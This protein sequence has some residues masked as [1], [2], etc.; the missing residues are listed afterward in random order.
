MDK[1][2]ELEEHPEDSSDP[3]PGPSGSSG[4]A[5][6]SWQPV[7]SSFWST[8]SST[9][10]FGAQASVLLKPATRKRKAPK[11]LTKPKK[12]VRFI[13]QSSKGTSHS[14]RA[15][16]PLQRKNKR[17]ADCNIGAVGTRRSP[18]LAT[19][20]ESATTPPTESSS[21]TTRI[22]RK[23]KTTADPAPALSKTPGSGTT[24]RSKPA[25]GKAG[26]TS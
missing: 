14:S 1:I 19:Q 12:Q 18:R 20:L 22:T 5:S 17:V 13:A 7:S 23:R 4:F 15:Q 10:T 11:R 25:P 8:S 6:S 3:A 26:N 2:I 21:I 9:V 16:T 24:K